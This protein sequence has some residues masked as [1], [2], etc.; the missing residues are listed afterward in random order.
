[1]TFLCIVAL[2]LSLLTMQLAT[3]P[4]VKIVLTGFRVKCPIFFVRYQLNLELVDRF[5]F[6]NVPNSNFTK[7][8]PVGAALICADE[9]T[10]VWKQIGIFAMRWRLK[11]IGNLRIT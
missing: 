1:M 6:L 8:L 9:Q 5:F 2:L 7:I 11:G 4:T 3:Q 10:D